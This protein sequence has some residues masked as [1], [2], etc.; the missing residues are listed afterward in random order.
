M[1]FT[2]AHTHN[3]IRTRGSGWLWMWT[4]RRKNN[5]S[6]IYVLVICCQSA[7]VFYCSNQPALCRVIYIRVCVWQLANKTHSSLQYCAKTFS[8]ASGDV[9]TYKIRR[10]TL[11]QV[12]ASEKNK[13]WLCYLIKYFTGVRC[14]IILQSVN[15]SRCCCGCC[16]RHLWLS[17][18]SI[19]AFRAT[20]TT[21]WSFNNINVFCWTTQV[22][23][24]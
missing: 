24:V 16:L 23:Y 11:S 22:V 14:F 7:S 3:Y 1:F 6:P 9:D 2:H 5:H 12:I 13:Y 19:E 10:R 20:T 8:I 17:H 4:R 15:I 18:A 21:I